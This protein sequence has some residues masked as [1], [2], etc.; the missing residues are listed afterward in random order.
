MLLTTTI[1]TKTIGNKE[2]FHGLTFS[3]EPHE[4]VAIIGRNGVGKT[5]LFRM[6]TGEDTD[7]TGTI[8]LSRGT[9]LVSTAQEHHTI[10]SQSVIDYILYNLPE[11]KKLKH[12]IDTYPLDMGDDLKKIEAYSTALDRFSQLGYYEIE[13]TIIARLARYQITE[14]M[15]RASMIQLSG[16]QKRFVEMVRVEVSNADI[17]LIDEPTNHMDYVAKAAF[18]QWFTTRPRTTIVITHDRDVLQWVDKVIEIKD[19]KAKTFNGNYSAYLKQNATATAASINDYH[20]AL[21][22]LDNLHKKILWA[23][24][25]KPSW[26]GTADQRNPFEVMERRFQKEYDEIEKNMIKPSFWI[27]QESVADLTKKASDSYDK[28]KAKNIHLHSLATDSHSRELL[29][30]KELVLGYTA[31]L[32]QPLTLTLQHGS[33]LQLIGRNGAGK[34]TLVKAIAGMYFHQPI[35]TLKGGIITCDPKLR[36][37]VYEQELG[38]ELMELTLAEAI[39][40]IHLQQNLDV[41][42][43]IIMRVMSDYLFDPRQDGRLPVVQL[44]GGQKARLQIIKMLI[45]NPNLLILDEPTNHL[46]LPS[47]EELEQALKDYHGAVL[48]VSHDSYFAKNIGGDQLV[49][50]L[51]ASSSAISQS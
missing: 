50:T 48:Y 40:Q 22:T 14:P 21:K 41:N 49:M 46:D 36:L 51:F 27:D 2:L 42:S 28:F 4:K 24:A 16:G 44:S 35:P 7:F 1:D 29:Q 30:I 39:E 17:A 32:F 38:Q 10:G 43:E 26:H 37:S 33:R 25:R 23:R 45:S 11:Y 5:T 6:L 31:P 47:I 8:H 13:D 3:I 20:I 19:G 12:I 34:T 15:A 18:I 9:R